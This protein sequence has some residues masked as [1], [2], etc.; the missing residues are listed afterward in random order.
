MADPIPIPAA[1]LEGIEAVRKSGRTNMLARDTVAAIAL[2]LG[3][4]DAA[5]WLDDKTNQKTYAQG[6]FN[7]FTE[8]ENPTR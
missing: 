3:Y 4:V 8:K 7:G 1:V 5:F 2:E 6:I